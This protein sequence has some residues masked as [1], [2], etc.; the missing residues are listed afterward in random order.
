MIV[1]DII[2]SNCRRTRT[3]LHVM[4]SLSDFP[5]RLRASTEHPDVV[6]TRAQ[7]YYAVR[8]ASRTQVRSAVLKL[9]DDGE[10]IVVLK[11]QPKGDAENVSAVYRSANGALVVPT[12]QVF[13]RFNDE[14]SVETQAEELRRLGYVIAQSL[15]Y[16]PNA[17]WLRHLNDDIAAALSNLHTLE[18]LPCVEN[19]E[20][21]LLSQRA[22]RAP[23]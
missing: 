8:D 18:A 19:V 11:G 21:Q 22:L 13:I 5:P 15:A 1:A 16:A 9:D 14:V 23:S 4:S 12:G 3:I 10:V 20:P 17:A 2:L 7:D 6:Y